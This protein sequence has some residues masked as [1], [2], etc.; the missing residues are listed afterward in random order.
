MGE[1]NMDHIQQL[2]SALRDALG[3]NAAQALEQ[4]AYYSA[5]G[6]ILF[7]ACGLVL[8]GVVSIFYRPWKP[9]GETRPVFSGMVPLIWML[10][11][12]FFAWQFFHPLYW[13]VLRDPSIG[14]AHGLL[15]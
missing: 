2:A 9:A 14:V 11:L 15:Q 7:G 3:D 5:M 4:A 1:E 10:G 6:H 8:P 12:A 13:S